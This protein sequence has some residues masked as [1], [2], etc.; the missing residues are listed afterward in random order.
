MEKMV[1]VLLHFSN[2]KSGVEEV[3]SSG[4]AGFFADGSF[5]EADPRKIQEMAHSVKDE[6]LLANFCF[7]SSPDDII[8]TIEKYWRAGATHVELVTHSF[9]D[10]VKFVGRKVLPYFTE[11]EDF[12]VQC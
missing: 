5:N 1:E 9:I 10:K 3:K 7:V 2:E 6:T 4:E 8:E 11:N 12:T